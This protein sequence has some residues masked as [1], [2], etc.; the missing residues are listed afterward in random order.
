M[1]WCFTIFS[2]G[3]S[4]HVGAPFF[5]GIGTDVFSIFV[6]CIEDIVHF[7]CRGSRSLAPSC[8]AEPEGSGLFAL[9]MAPSL[10][11]YTGIP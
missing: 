4:A 2:S 10:K 11:K 6:S 7:L 3:R 9:L 8:L 1:S 5:L